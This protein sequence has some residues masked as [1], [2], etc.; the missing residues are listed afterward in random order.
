MKTYKQQLNKR[1]LGR[2][3]VD[4]KITVVNTSLSTESLCEEA[5]R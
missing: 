3:N 4:V 2:T 1:F 5:L